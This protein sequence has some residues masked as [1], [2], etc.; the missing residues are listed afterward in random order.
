MRAYNSDNVNELHSAHADFIRENTGVEV[1]P[2]Q[3]Y[4]TLVTRM[5][6][7]N[8]EAATEARNAKDQARLETLQAQNEKIEAQLAERRAK[9][10]A[11]IEALQSPENKPKRG[12]PRESAANGEGQPVE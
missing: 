9:V 6:F 2:E 8:T 10:Q 7:G 12:R 3:V 4:A 1:S 5:A 11:R